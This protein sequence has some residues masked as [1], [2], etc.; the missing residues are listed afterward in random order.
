MDFRVH[1][2]P[3][4]MFKPLFALADRKLTSGGTVRRI[5]TGDV[6]MPCR[7]SLQDATPGEEVILTNFTHLADPETPY[8]ANGPIFVRKA[9][10]E[11]WDRV[12]EVP[13]DYLKRLLSMRAYDANNMI[14]TANVAQGTELLDNA[15]ELFALSGTEYI[16]VHHAA[17]GCYHFRIDPV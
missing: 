5:A 16:H 9:A 2:L 15:K 8:R 7:V 4:A 11:T 12:N 6:A 10:M 17:F 3:A 1:G 14:V 13:R